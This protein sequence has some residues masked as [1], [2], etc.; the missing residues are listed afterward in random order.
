MRIVHFEKGGAPGIAADEGSGW[1]GLTERESGFPGTLPELIA[2]GADL[3]RVGRDLLPMQA[4]DLNAVR[5]LPPVPKPPKILC[6]GLNY[7]D[8]LEESGLKKPVYLEIFARFAT[9]LIAHGELIRLPPESSTLDYEAE[10]AVVIGRGGRRIKRDRALDHVAGYSLFNDATI[11]EFQLRTPQ[12]TM[13]KNFDGTGAFGP[14]L[15]TSDALPPGAHGLRIQGRLN[16]RVMQESSTDKLIFNVSALIEM[17]SVAISLE[18]GDVIITGTPGG[19]GAARKPPVFM[20][21]GDVFEVEIEGMG[22]LS[23]PV[24]RESQ[25]EASR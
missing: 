2:Q 25:E 3:S 11:R 24:Q 12:W 1:H 7:D 23:N 18:P 6:V 13:G 8:H 21:P 5:I 22:V 14:W 15:V 9:S 19:V 10:L 16:G 17:I 4:I 20:Q